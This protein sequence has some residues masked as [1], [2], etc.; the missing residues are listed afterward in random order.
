MASTRTASTAFPALLFSSSSSHAVESTVVQPPAP[1]PAPA[2]TLATEK[3]APPS[4]ADSNLL[5]DDASQYSQYSQTSPSDEAGSR[6]PPP[7]Y[8]SLLPL[9][10]VHRLSVS[11]APPEFSQPGEHDGY[12]GRL[13][14]SSSLPSVQVPQTFPFLA[15]P[16]LSI[17][18]EPTT[19]SAPSLPPPPPPSS[20]LAETQTP[21]TL[22]KTRGRAPRADAREPFEP[23]RQQQQ[24]QQHV[25]SAPLR[26]HKSPAR[27]LS[28]ATQGRPRGRSTS[29]QPP[30]GPDQASRLY[31]QPQPQPQAQ[32]LPPPQPVLGHVAFASTEYTLNA[33][34]PH[35]S[36]GSASQSPTRAARTLRRRSW[37]PSGG[38]DGG[39]RLR[40]KSHEPSA[41]THSPAWMLPP[42]PRA[43]YNVDPLI[44]GQKVPELWDDNGT[45]YVYFSAPQSDQGPSL[46][47]PLSAIKESRVLSSLVQRPA[48]APIS[49]RSRAQSLGG[50]DT[51]LSPD[52][53]RTSSPSPPLQPPTGAEFGLHLPPL[54]DANYGNGNGN[55][56]DANLERL[57]ALRNLFALLMGQ[58]LVATR[59]CPTAFA[60]LLQV[61]ALLREFDFGPVSAG[62]SSFG[63]AVDGSLGF[64]L[65]Q[66]G[67]ADVRFNR[68]KTLEA[69]VLGEHLRCWA[70]YNEAFCHAVGKYLALRALKKSPLW[71][72]ISSNTLQRLERAHLDLVS[73]Q[74][75]VNTR[76]EQFEF[77]SLFAGVGNS[78]SNPEYR[79]LR[80]K[81]WRASFGEMRSFVLKYYKTKFGSWPPKASSRHNDF[82]ESGL[83]RLVLKM[84]YADLCS[85]YD[86]LVDRTSLTTRGGEDG[87]ALGGPAS[88]APS[89]AS[90]FASGAGAGSAHRPAT[91]DPATNPAMIA[92]RQMLGEFD[93]SSPPVLPPMPFD[94]PKLPTVATIRETYQEMSAKDQARFDRNLQSYEL[95]LIL[96]KSH[97]VDADR[98][99]ASPFLAAFEAF[100]LREAKKGKSETELTEMRIGHWLFLYVV[101]QSMP[102]LVIDAPSLQYTEGVEYFLCEPPQGRPPWVEDAGEVR[103]AWFQTAG[104]AGPLVELS[105][106]VLLYSVEAT[107]HRSHCWLAAKMWASSDTLE[108]PLSSMVVAAAAA[109][110]DLVPVR[111]PSDTA[112]VIA[113]EGVPTYPLLQPMPGPDL[114]LVPPA[115]GRFSASPSLVNS[116]TSLSSDA[117]FAATASATRSSS[118]EYSTAA[119]DDDTT[120]NHPSPPRSVSPELPPSQQLQP[121]INAP[122]LQRRDNYEQLQ[123]QAYARHASIGWS[124]EPVKPD[125]G[126]PA[127]AYGS[128]N[129]QSEI[130]N[131]RRI[132]SAGNLRTMMD[133]NIG[134]GLAPDAA[135][136]IGNSSNKSGSKRQDFFNAEST[137]DSILGNMDSENSSGA[138]TS[139]QLK[140][141][142]KRN[143]FLPFI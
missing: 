78:T 104:G 30:G 10:A 55:Y 26:L 45:L 129:R 116:T 1:T 28:P 74:D 87:A 46:K 56:A 4:P 106:D 63:E 50:R 14:L 21:S 5:D 37:L 91:A 65:S 36:Q 121:P 39:N 11:G 132:A 58:P 60:A 6:S 122:W 139:N 54:P 19:M 96:I 17:P 113:A 12:G 43:D 135:N 143:S 123:Q 94:I 137:F 29:A 127:L 23:G 18:E 80:F 15:P 40:S 52:A 82:T 73:R 110:D 140:K 128:A 117:A 119:T 31:Q 81:N 67:L 64:C 49:N 16:P 118:R 66:T 75:S 2:Q 69:V 72:R 77:P 25:V 24:Q 9:A 107:Y 41:G 13:P 48:S 138:S 32:A 120:E 103:K 105:A 85:V 86:L 141:A 108:G 57:V 68:E 114:P 95:Q 3:A 47:V 34:S 83:N 33:H 76:L 109:P 70:L 51:L 102:M 101:L 124:L 22:T 27:N 115:L 130:F 134:G 98:P 112:P 42:G 97:N 131:T 90:A 142:K 53:Q 44:Y 61:A 38:S 35:S 92:L 89:S 84:L 99:E 125:D 79:N 100:E 133:T 62:S 136:S 20:G 59:G 111:D 8:G 93:Q 88:A 126:D 71:G 7:N